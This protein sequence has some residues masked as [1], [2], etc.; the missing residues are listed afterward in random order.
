VEVVEMVVEVNSFIE[1]KLIM[2]LP[3]FMLQDTQVLLVLLKLLEHK[4]LDILMQRLRNGLLR[5]RSQ[6][7]L[8]F[9]GQHLKEYLDLVLLLDHHLLLPH[10]H[11]HHHH[12]LLE[13]AEVVAEAVE[14]AVEVTFD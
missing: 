1:D 8:Q 4:L 10:L 9:L 3:Q 5:L 11:L 7:L 13:A 6:D 14:V 12:Q 2:D